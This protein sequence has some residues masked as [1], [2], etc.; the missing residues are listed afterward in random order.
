MLGMSG[1][2]GAH[3]VAVARGGAR[4]GLAPESVEA[5]AA[6]RAQVEQLAASPEPVYGIST[7]FGALEDTHIAEE[8]RTQLQHAVVRSHAASMGDPVEAEVVRAL[9]FLRL[10]TL[11]SGRT[12][13]RPVVAEGLVA[14]LNAQVTPVVR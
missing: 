3:V 4:V 1:V 13:A 12:G 6:S 9:M 2:T 5:M 14:L 8:R 10:R 11:A 7:G